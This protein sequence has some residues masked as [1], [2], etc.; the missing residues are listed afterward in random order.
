ME[1]SAD[2]AGKAGKGSTGGLGRQVWHTPTELFKV[3]P[4]CASG[5]ACVL[6]R[7]TFQRES[8]YGSQKTGSELL[9]FG[10]KAF[11]HPSDHAHQQIPSVCRIRN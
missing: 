3:C 2:E 9:L 7:S 6:Q 1:L 10:P 8:T 11:Q 4:A 5:S